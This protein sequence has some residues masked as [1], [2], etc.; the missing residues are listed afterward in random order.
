MV[1]TWLVVKWYVKL[2]AINDLRAESLHFMLHLVVVH[3]LIRL[4]ISLIVII[5]LSIL[6]Q[7]RKCLTLMR[8][9]LTLLNQLVALT[10]VYIRLLK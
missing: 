3:F 5:I 2:V 4:A 6:E 7:H 9:I 10:I 8:R 1:S